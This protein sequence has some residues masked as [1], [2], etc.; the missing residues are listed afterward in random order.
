MPTSDYSVQLRRAILPILKA[1][2]KIAAA[3]GGRVYSETPTAIPAW[4]FIRFGFAIG[5]PEEWSC[6]E[7][8]DVSFTVNVFSKAAGTDECARITRLVCAVLDKRQITLEVDTDTGKQAGAYLLVTRTQIMRDG[9]EA[10]AHHGVVSFEAMV[11][12]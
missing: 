9:S 1:D 12:G 3:V 4:P 8:A 5:T 10:D 11:S 2:A 7:G 6:A